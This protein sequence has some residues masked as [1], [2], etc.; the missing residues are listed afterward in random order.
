MRT[1]QPE[2][3]TL[4]VRTR[5]P[6]LKVI[7]IDEFL[8]LELPPRKD[9]LQP[10]LPQ[11][12]LAMIH[13]RRGAG[14]TFVALHIAWAV[15][16]GGKFLRWHAPEAAGVLYIDGEM[17]AVSLQERLARM[18][19]AS[20]AQ[21]SA[22]F[23]LLTP[24]LNIENG[25]PDLSS[26]EGQDRVDGCV[27]DDH[28]LIL[29]DNLSS[30]CRGGKENEAESWLGVQ[31]WALRHRAAGRSIL[32]VHHSG[33]SG[34]QRGTSR[35]ED[36]L[37]TVI[38]LRQPMGFDVTEG[39]RF[40]VHFEKARGLVGSDVE[41]FEALLGED[42]D[43]RL[44]W[45]VRSACR[46]DQILEMV[47]DGMKPTEIAQDLGIGRATVYREIRKAKDA[48]HLPDNVRRLRPKDER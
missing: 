23:D 5:M 15:A 33:K 36:V 39:A 24:D 41:T 31:T 4:S 43:G 37:D 3:R 29:V 6:P 38:Q 19:V 47:G 7:G 1:N 30:L 17:P 9:L 18:A 12:G 2:A 16:T 20:D 11:Q 8:K 21:P 32:F 44:L 25:M 48:G 27:R 26:T 40:E 22:A 35:R 10:W 14:K 45:T 42:V 34:L 13:A 46:S 28:S